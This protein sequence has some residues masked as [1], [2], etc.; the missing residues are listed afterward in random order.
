MMSVGR[1][2]SVWLTLF[3]LALSACGK[4]PKGPIGIIGTAGCLMN[5]PR[6]DPPGYDLTFAECKDHIA[7][8]PDYDRIIR[9]A[10]VDC[11]APPAGPMCVVGDAAVICAD[12]RPMNSSNVCFNRQLIDGTCD[13][14]F[15]EA[16]NFVVTTPDYWRI[17]KE[18][19]HRRCQ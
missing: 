14:P 16:V 8:T 12:E 1:L 7:T 4:P 6:R 19:Y 2:R 9:K 5:D 18:Y 15:P 3:V 10:Y 17:L 13:V 11:L